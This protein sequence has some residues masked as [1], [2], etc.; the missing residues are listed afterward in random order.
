MLT[1]KELRRLAKEARVL[2]MECVDGRAPA[3]AYGTLGDEFGHCAMG[4]IIKRACG[5]PFAT[6]HEWGGPLEPVSRLVVDA[7]NTVS[8]NRHA[9]VVFPLLALADALEDASKASLK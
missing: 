6:N 1:K 9:A 2:A 5:S 4:W 7:N 8:T 3:L